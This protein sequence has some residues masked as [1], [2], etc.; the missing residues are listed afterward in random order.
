MNDEGMYSPHMRRHSHRIVRLF[1]MN[2]ATFENLPS[3]YMSRNRHIRPLSFLA[4]SEGF[5]SRPIHKAYEILQGL[6]GLRFLI[7]RTE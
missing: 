2:E 1:Q 5:A 7:R 3:A 4:P 6:L